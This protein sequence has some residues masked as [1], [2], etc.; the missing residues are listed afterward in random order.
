MKEDFSQKTNYFPN[1]ASNSLYVATNSIN[2]K[3][4]DIYN[5]L[6][7]LVLSNSNSNV[8]DVSSIASG[9]YYLNVKSK[10]GSNLIL[11]KFIKQ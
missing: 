9:I 2:I 8:I 10:D 5:A 1:P 11:D 3:Q 6:G 4:I 7:K